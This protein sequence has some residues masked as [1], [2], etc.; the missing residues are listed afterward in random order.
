MQVDHSK[1][2]SRKVL[3]DRLAEQMP[4]LLSADVDRPADVVSAIDSHPVR[5]TLKSR[6]AS[7]IAQQATHRAVGRVSHDLISKLSVQDSNSGL[8][9]SFFE[10]PN[11][12]EFRHWR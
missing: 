4:V 5:F 6:D 8:L 1:T 9:D 3:A 2:L 7:R 11:A 12:R 10:S